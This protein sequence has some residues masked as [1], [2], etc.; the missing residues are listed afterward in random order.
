MF[1]TVQ[2]K[3]AL[4]VSAFMVLSVAGLLYLRY[5]Q[6]HNTHIVYQSIEKEKKE[7]FNN[8]VSINGRPLEAF[9]RDYSLRDDIIGMAKTSDS[10]RGPAVIGGGLITFGANAAW[11]FRS[12]FSLAY[13]TGNVSYSGDGLSVITPQMV[14]ELFSDNALCHFYIETPQGLMDVRGSSMRPAGDGK[15]AGYFLAGTLWTKEYL[16]GMAEASFSELS[17]VPP[18]EMQGAQSSGNRFNG[19]ISFAVPLHGADGS[20]AAMLAV[21]MRPSF[22]SDINRTASVQFI[23]TLYFEFILLILLAGF[24]LWWIIMPLAVISRGL[25]SAD[26]FSLRSL[27]NDKSE[28]GAITRL[29]GQ[30]FDQQV[31]L[32]KETA[33]R[34]QTELA[35][36]KTR[37]EMR[38][39]LQQQAETYNVTIRALQDEIK[40]LKR[41]QGIN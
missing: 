1:S 18:D 9:A 36:E 3:V 34:A 5:S 16:A 40:E 12:D 10:A 39:A 21:V 29:I 19:I 25:N 26:V 33:G 17:V 30:F 8:L 11:V 35:L 15:P 28:F 24:L 41:P 37:G 20:A 38:Y 31:E 7:L 4:A 32:M 14:G 22:F 27:K 2:A 6:T 23:L 13:S